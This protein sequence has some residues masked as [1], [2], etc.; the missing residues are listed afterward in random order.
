MGRPKLITH[1]PP[2][3]SLTECIGINAAID[4]CSVPFSP[5]PQELVWARLAASAERAGRPGTT[6]TPLTAIPLQ[7]LHAATVLY[8]WQRE[9]AFRLA[10][11]GIG[12]LKD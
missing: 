11:A 7:P 8:G 1:D 9:D 12:R 4:T 10:V 2:P 3:S 6:A 5:F